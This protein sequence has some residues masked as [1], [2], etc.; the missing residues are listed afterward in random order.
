MFYHPLKL[1]LFDKTQ[2][3]LQ[4]LK[5][6][7]LE[8]LLLFLVSLTTVLSFESVGSMTVIVFLV[9]PAMTILPWSRSFVQLLLGGQLVAAINV[10]I[11]Y[12][13]AMMFDL[14]MSGTCAVTALVVFCVS[15]FFKNRLKN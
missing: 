9:A 14:T 10:A 4:G 2:A 12:Y 13:L 7:K 8:L 5:I 1:Y 11:G 3:A 6:G 15:H